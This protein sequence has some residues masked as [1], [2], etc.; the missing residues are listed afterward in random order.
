M[1]FLLTTN[2]AMTRLRSSSR[3]PRIIIHLL[4]TSEGLARKA[5]HAP[6]FGAL[7]GCAGERGVARLR[8]TRRDEEGG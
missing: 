3:E 1:G 6:G 2:G 7:P 8:G 4:F 5:L